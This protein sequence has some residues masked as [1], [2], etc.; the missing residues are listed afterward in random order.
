MQFNGRDFRE[1]IETAAQTRL[2]VV[3]NQRYVE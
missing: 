3:D 1:T 2:V